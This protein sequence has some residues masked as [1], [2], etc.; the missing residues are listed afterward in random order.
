MI[1]PDYAVYCAVHLVKFQYP[2][3]INTPVFWR[4]ELMRLGP[5]MLNKWRLTSQ[6]DVPA[7]SLPH[8]AVPGCGVGDAQLIM[9]QVSETRQSK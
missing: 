5:H 1:F 2:V 7:Q 6:C 9:T 4:K 3:H 8:K